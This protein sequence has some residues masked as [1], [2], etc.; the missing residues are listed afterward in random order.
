MTRDR[1]AT[2]RGRL[3]AAAVTVAVLA[4]AAG[5]FAAGVGTY[6]QAD[7]RL[8]GSQIHTFA[9][10]G[11][12]VTVI[13]G[14]FRLAVGERR[15]S[16]RNAVAWVR[17]Q[18]AGGVTRHDVTLYV[19]G[20]AKVVEPGGAA[21]TDRV[22]LV[23]VRFQGR[24]TAR[25]NMVDKSLKDYPLYK[26]ASAFRGK[27][28]TTKPVRH[29]PPLLIIRET[30]PARIERPVPVG[31]DEPPRRAPAPPVAASIQPV[32]FYAKAVTTERRGRGR[33]MIGRR[34]VYLSQ[35][36]PASEL[37][38][39][40]RAQAGV[41]FTA[42]R[43]EREDVRT[44]RTPKIGGV[45]SPLP[46][47][48]STG[49]KE[50]IIGAY[51]EGDVV[52]ARGERY[53]RGP[54]AYY[55]FT[56][57]RAIVIEPVFRT[58][59][60]ERNI[61]VYI[62]ARIGRALSA[63]ELWFKDAKVSTSDFYSPTY[64]VGAQTAYI[65]DKTPYDAKGV[66]VGEKRW[67]A[68]LKHTTFNIRS[69]PVWYWPY[70]ECEVEEIHTPLRKFQ[71][72]RHGHFGFGVETEWYLFRF[73]GLVAPEGFGGRLEMD[74]YERGWVGGVSL[75]YARANHSGYA[76]A[77]GLVDRKQLDQFGDEREDI[78]A[79][80]TRGRLLMRHKHMLPRAWELQFELSYLCDENYLEQFFPS[81]AYAGKEQETLIY[82]KKQGDNWAVTSLLK[83]RM[84]AFLTQTESIPDLGL[85]LIGES[86]FDDR[87]TVYSESRAGFKRYRPGTDAG[88]TRSRIFVRAD[89][90][91]EAQLPL[92]FGPINVVPYA[93]GRATYWDDSPIHP[94]ECRPYGQVGVKANTHLWRVFNGV[95]SRLW[96]LHRLRHIMTPEVAA[97]VAGSGGVQ[98]TDVFGMDP[99]V[100]RLLKRS[101][102]FSLGLY[103]RL[104]TK[105][106]NPG[107][108]HTSDWMRFNL[109]AGFYDS[110]QQSLPADGR[111]FSYRPEYSLDR[112]HLN[113]EW[114]WHISDSTT[115]MADTNYDW[116]DEVFGRV[117][118]GIAVHR[119]P[120]MGYFIGARAIRDFNSTVGTIGGY[121]KINRKYSVNAFQQYDFDFNNGSNLATSI[122]IVRKFPRW[123]GAFTFS[124]DDATDSVSFFLTFWPEGIPEFRL[125]S[126]QLELL[127]VSSMN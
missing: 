36:H 3:A 65:M 34:N 104:Q 31:P 77:Y 62:R 90:R 114:F 25:G 40:I 45:D 126:G 53:M 22:M 23:H 37:F 60:K 89:T 68:Q 56:T 33:V 122:S 38:L 88:G 124:Y 52:I 55:D 19:E 41:I 10:R 16:G 79:P 119:S 35:G 118:A 26:R 64:D 81:E 127:G 105:R 14:D 28:A 21:T 8:A 50:T 44:P 75:K 15:I 57:D 43:P 24:L 11:E 30:P 29:G 47:P 17:A 98:P 5:S 27:A 63:R 112:N 71:V 46:D 48:N 102:G 78:A 121:Y 93:V 107:D 110:A 18:K 20:D 76:L 101:S 51:L 86:L 67:L 58:R 13:L 9:D 94:S 87:L 70:T 116:D 108:R 96:D 42:R 49:W 80:P 95:E 66:R 6:I 117:N 32:S 74:Y 73:L 82:A 85:H 61:P 1:W 54:R 120:R 113:A 12:N 91:N 106:G 84:N 92:N 72:G 83:Y 123:Y 115:I 99:D 103:Q 69:V 111:F 39:E 2:G 125:G 100:E 59:Q 7:A 97:F 109:V 4:A